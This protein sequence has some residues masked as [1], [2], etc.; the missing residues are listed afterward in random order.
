M[1]L[2]TCLPRYGVATQQRVVLVHTLHGSLLSLREVADGLID[3]GLLLS[4]L[5]TT[6]LVLQ[7]EDASLCAKLCCADVGQ[8]RCCLIG[9]TVASL[10]TTD[11]LEAHL[12]ALHALTCTSELTVHTLQANLGTLHTL[13][14]ARQLGVNTLQPQTSPLDACTEELVCRRQTLKA[15]L[16]SLHGRANTR[17][18]QLTTLQC[19]AKT[20]LRPL[21]TLKAEVRAKLHS[22]HCLIVG[23]L[24]ALCLDS[25]ELGLERTFGFGVLNGLTSTTK[26]TST[27]GLACTLCAGDICLTTSGVNLQV[28]DS[29]LVWRHKLLYSSRV[30]HLRDVI[31]LGVGRI[32]CVVFRLT[33]NFTPVLFGTQPHLP[34]ICSAL[35][36]TLSLPC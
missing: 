21:Q 23:R 19:S 28:Y 25:S 9:Q 1:V 14:S 27:S 24:R 2:G 11:T 6:D 34:D 16:L 4:L 22:L 15:S 17:Q 3:H 36:V 20:L 7:A 35:S 10:R 5:L 30:S 18:T 12:S 8:V 26:R 31:L 32:T 29:L 13:G 33:R